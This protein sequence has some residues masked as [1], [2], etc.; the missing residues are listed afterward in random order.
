[1]SNEKRVW[2]V[3]PKGASESFQLS[4]GELYTDENG[5]HLGHPPGD[6]RG[7]FATFPLGTLV[8]CADAAVPSASPVGSAAVELVAGEVAHFDL[9]PRVEIGA[10]N[11]TVKSTEDAAALASAV[12]RSA[13]RI[14][15]GL[16][17][18]F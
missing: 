10:I 9:S 1:M 16:F 13:W 3:L 17:W 2:N 6:A 8:W 7:L 11:I 18:P 14:R 12:K 15:P 5:V 4:C